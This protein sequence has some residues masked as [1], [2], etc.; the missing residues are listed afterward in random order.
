MGGHWRHY[1]VVLLLL[2]IIIYFITFYLGLV[3]GSA[4]VLIEFFLA[5]SP[6]LSPLRVRVLTRTIKL[7]NTSWLLESDVFSE[8]SAYQT[9]VAAGMHRYARVSFSHFL[10]L[11]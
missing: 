7:G 10:L 9:K 6:R 2:I 8:A 4:F 11:F 5:P 1:I 3:A